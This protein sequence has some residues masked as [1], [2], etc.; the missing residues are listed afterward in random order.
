MPTYYEKRSNPQKLSH[1]LSHAIQHMNTAR[2]VPDGYVLLYQNSNYS[3]TTRQCAYL[4]AKNK[5]QWNG[6]VAAH[7]AVQK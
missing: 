7:N 4:C 5:V 1:A 6:R 2:K 3:N